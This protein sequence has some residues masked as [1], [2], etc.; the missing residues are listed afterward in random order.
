VVSTSVA[1]ARK[2]ALATVQPPPNE[3]LAVLGNAS[4]RQIWLA[5]WHALPGHSAAVQAV[6][7]MTPRGPV[8]LASDGTH[9][10]ANLIRRSPFVISV[11]A[12]K[13]LQS[14]TRMM[15]LAGGL[16]RR[17]RPEAPP[18]VP[19]R[20]GQRHRALGAPRGAEAVRAG[21]SGPPRRFL[22]QRRTS[23]WT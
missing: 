2:A 7:V 22:E 13:T 17:A 8:L 19:G 11:D 16:D 4:F 18:A 10:F 9:D 3:A 23:S 6:R 21:G 1:S 12:A 5:T 15:E 20:H 14:Y